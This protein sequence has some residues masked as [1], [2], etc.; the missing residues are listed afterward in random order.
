M[1][2]KFSWFLISISFLY[3]FSLRAQFSVED[4]S[5]NQLHGSDS[6]ESAEKELEFFF[7]MQQTVAAIKPDAYQTKGKKAK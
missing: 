3:F 6:A 7:P 2:K 5:I 4:V 1:I